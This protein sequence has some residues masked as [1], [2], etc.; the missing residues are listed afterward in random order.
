MT[1]GALFVGWGPIIPGREHQAKVVLGEAMAFCTNL[2][3]NKIIDGFEAV[4]LEPH[5]GDLEG[6]VMVKGDQ[7]SLA[8]LR[9]SEEFLKTVVAV[10]LVH[11][12]VRV[13]GAYTGRELQIVAGLW[14]EQENRILKS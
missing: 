2:Q 14:D 3:E 5:G 1:K 4:F 9:T 10:Q 8:R 12:K 11:S 7:D 6:F 13:V